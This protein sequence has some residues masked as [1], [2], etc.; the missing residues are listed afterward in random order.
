MKYNKVGFQT[1]LKHSLLIMAVNKLL[2]KKS[3]VTTTLDI[4][5]YLIKK[6]PDHKWTQAFVSNSMMHLADAGIVSYAD[7]GTYRIYCHNN[8]KRA[9]KAVANETM[10]TNTTKVNSVSNPTSTAV[11]VNKIK[12]TKTPSNT[13]KA[14]RISKTKA[15]ELMEGNK[16]RF[17]TAEFIDKKGQVRVMNCQ[18]L[19]DQNKSKLGYVKVKEASLMRS[20]T[21]PKKTIRQINLQTISSLKIGGQLYKI[22]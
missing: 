15:Y 5:N 18:F 7:N 13:T 22:S 1:V 21:D 20:E 4:K 10:L 8:N 16:G 6:H 3:G 12:K 17:F 19:K 2:S 14:K 9:A 11:V